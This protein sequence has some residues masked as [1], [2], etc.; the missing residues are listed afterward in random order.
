MQDL[1]R[2]RQRKST[3]G[4]LRCRAVVVVVFMTI[5]L[6]CGKDQPGSTK[7]TKREPAVSKPNSDT[8]KTKDDTTT[9]SQKGADSKK[10]PAKEDFTHEVIAASEYYTTGPQQGRPPDGTFAGGTKV[11][12]ISDAGSYSLVRSERGIQAYVATDAIRKIGH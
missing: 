12:L 6:G 4:V 9:A 11:V 7:A 10:S 3:V 5:G 8:A 2:A 1:T